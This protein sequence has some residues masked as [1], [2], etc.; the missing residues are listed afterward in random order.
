[1]IRVPSFFQR[2]L[3]WVHEIG[4]EVADLPGGEGAKEACG[5]DGV[6]ELACFGDPRF[7]KGGFFGETAQGDGSVG[8]RGDD[9]GEEATV[10]QFENGHAVFGG[11]DGAGIYDVFQQVAEVGGAGAGKVWAEF[12]AFAVEDVTGG[13]EI[14]KEDTSGWEIGFVADVF[15]ESFVKFFDAFLFCGV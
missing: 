15:A 1:M 13:T 3:L 11:N 14:L 6:G 9:S 10:F 12:A 2:H 4:D 7:F 5:H 8:R